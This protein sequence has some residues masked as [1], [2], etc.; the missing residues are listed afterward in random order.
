[1]LWVYGRYTF[2]NLFRAGI[3]LR[4]QNLLPYQTVPAL[5]GLMAPCGS[6][7][8]HRSHT[9]QQPAGSENRNRNENVMKVFFLVH[10]CAHIG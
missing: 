1:M 7:G 8:H 2:V 4:R 10:F 5:K 3:V 6:P 9:C